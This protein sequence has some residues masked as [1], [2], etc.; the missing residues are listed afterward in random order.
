MEILSTTPS[1]DLQHTIIQTLGVLGD[2][3][4]A[5]L[6]RSF[7]HHENHH[8]RKRAQAALLRLESQSS[9]SDHSS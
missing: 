3:R 1:S 8:I 6:I 9:S 5:E 7:Q 4:A 2:A